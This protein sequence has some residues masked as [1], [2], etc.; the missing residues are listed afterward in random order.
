MPLLSLTRLSG[1]AR[2]LPVSISKRLFLSNTLILLG[3]GV[4]RI[5]LAIRTCARVFP[6][7]W[8][9]HCSPRFFERGRLTLH[10]HSP[11]D[12]NFHHFAFQGNWFLDFGRRY[13]VRSRAV[14]PAHSN[15]DPAGK[16]PPCSDNAV[17]VWVV[18]GIDEKKRRVV[19][20]GRVPDG[21]TGQTGAPGVSK[22][23]AVKLE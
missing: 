4:A 7:G 18:F 19:F 8:R 17:S 1:H 13:P 12:G 21:L 10:P 14:H 16:I 9:G 3:E 5:F 23:L 11:K 15:F 2:G 6:P 22:G 20:R